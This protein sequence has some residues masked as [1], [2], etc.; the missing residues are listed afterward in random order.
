MRKWLWAF[1]LLI[2]LLGA[3]LFWAAS[4][5]DSYLEE[6]R[7]WLAEKASESVGRPTSFSEV[8]VGFRGGLS[9]RVKDLRIGDDPAFSREEFLRVDEAYVRLRLLPLLFGRYEIAR[10]VLERPEIHLVRT[11]RGLN[12][13]TLGQGREAGPRAGEEAPTE[14]KKPGPRAVEALPLLVS[15]VEVRSARVRYVDRTSAPPSEVLLDGVDLAVRDLGLDRPVSFRLG[16]SVLDAKEKNLEVS[17]KLGPLDL[18]RPVNTPLDIRIEAGPLSLGAVPPAF[19][20]FLPRELEVGGAL[21]GRAE[22]KGT[23]PSLALS[24]EL[25]ADDAEFA[26]GRVFRKPKG[27][28]ASLEVS[29][30]REGDV[31][32]AE[33][34]S[35]VAGDL[36]VA[37][38]AKARLG[39]PVRVDFEL[40]PRETK[41]RGLEGLLPALAPYDLEGTVLLDLRGRTDLPPKTPPELSGTV[42]LRK[43]SARVREVRLSLENAALRLDGDRAELP[44]TTVRVGGSP[45]DVEGAVT[46]LASRRGTIRARSD[47][48]AL[49][50]VG[51]ASP[52]AR[53]KEELRGLEVE[54]SFTGTRGEGTVRSADG[55]VRD[56]PYEKLELPLRYTNGTLRIENGTALVF[57]GKANLS[58]TYRLGDGGPPNFEL[59]VDLLGIDVSA[60]G[61]SFSATLA[62]LLEGKTDL[63]LEVRGSGRK[64]EEIQTTLDGEGDVEVKDGGIRDV[65]VPASLLGGLQGIQG[66]PNLLGSP[67]PGPYGELL[68]ERRTRFEVLRTRLTVQKGNILL[69]NLVADAKGFEARAEGQVSLGKELSLSG[70]LRLSPEFSQELV[71]RAAI[72][73]A[74]ADP[75]GRLEIPF[76]VEGVLPNVRPSPDREALAR[77]LTRS[78]VERGLDAVL[79][80]GADK[81]PSPA[82]PEDLLRKGLEE[83]LG[84]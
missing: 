49:E 66:L 21:R 25:E 64:W 60:A 16:A 54:A 53:T 59:V 15:D 6:H 3:A 33:K 42:T 35:F 39:K 47:R 61:R 82:G 27:L 14:G 26:Y 79:P 81:T 65:N 5:L 4:R 48:L 31:V 74:L 67:L 34:L 7:E 19:R 72:L 10:V 40:S 13:A 37:G 45:V 73:R 46:S 70:V 58:G 23:L 44:K 78:L 24:L 22:A 56:I 9:V 20:S 52:D 69:R 41:L 55:V 75:R 76:R 68:K 57:G 11:S 62:R 32:E 28:R 77:L 84:R 83:L 51:A 18:A 12:A 29:G 8:G 1:F 80:R 30:R 2:A 63:R 17:G 36:S 50:D 38:K 43:T 71:G